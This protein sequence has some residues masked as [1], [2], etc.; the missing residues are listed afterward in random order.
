MGKLTV[1][2]AYLYD[3]N[4]AIK[5]KDLKECPLE[6]IVLEQYHEF[7]PLFYKVLADMLPPHC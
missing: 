6:E 4:K 5:A 7:F 1:F 3:I 2:K